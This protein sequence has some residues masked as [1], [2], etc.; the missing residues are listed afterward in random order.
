MAWTVASPLDKVIVAIRDSLERNNPGMRFS[1]NEVILYTIGQN[2]QLR[3]FMETSPD[4]M[5][6]LKKLPINVK[7]L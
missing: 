3:R 4:S 5:K 7:L 2:P 1:K 6:L